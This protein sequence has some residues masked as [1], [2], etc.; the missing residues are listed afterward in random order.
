MNLKIGQKATR[1]MKVTEKQIKMFAELTGD[2]NPIHFDKEFASKTKF[3]KLIAQG[4]VTTGILNAIVGMDMPGPGTVFLSQNFKYIKPVYIGDTI[5]A[6]AEVLQIHKTKP[7]TQLKVTIKNQD[8]IIVLEG[9]AW[10]Y[11]MKPE[12]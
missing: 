5:T 12:K 4:G 11:T 6:E 8:D 1:S 2:Y 10:C 3:K 7:V 9:E